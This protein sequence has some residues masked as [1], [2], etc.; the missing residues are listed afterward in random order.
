MKAPAPGVY[1]DV[2]DSEYHSWE[3][4]SGSGLREFDRSPLHFRASLVGGANSGDTPARAFGRAAHMAVLQPHLFPLHFAQGPSYGRSAEGR[5]RLREIREGGKVALYSDDWERIQGI[6]KA[7]YSHPRMAAIVESQPATEV[8]IVWRDEAS[9]L[10]CKTRL[11]LYTPLAGGIVLD[12]KTT[13]DAQR[14]EFM[15]SIAKFG[16]YRQAAMNV[17]ACQAAQLEAAHWMA[18]AVETEVPFACALYRLRDEAIVAGDEEVSRLL[19]AVRK[20]HDTDTWPGYGEDVTD[21]DLPDWKYR[22]I[23]N[24]AWAAKE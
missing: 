17:R 14:H 23:E 2:P 19:A 11:D 10:T 8:S 18:L 21:I 22:Q 16:Y 1:Y 4:V 13:R 5:R 6:R 15:R 9:G 20:C 7:V 3:A 12:L 24:A